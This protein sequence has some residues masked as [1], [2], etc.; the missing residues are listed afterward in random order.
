M[1]DAV[2]LKKEKTQAF[3]KTLSEERFE[4]YTVLS[5]GDEAVALRLYEANAQLS[6]ALYIPLQALEVTL[7]NRIHTELSAKYDCFWFDIPD[8]LKAK[9]QIEGVG[10]TKGRLVHDK[11]KIEAGRIIAGLSFGFW[12]GLF[13]NQYEELWRSDL[14]KIVI[15]EERPSRRKQFAGPL[16][17]IREIR[18]RVAHHECII[19]WRLN[20]HYGHMKTI[21]KR[22]SPEAHYWM[23]NNSTFEDVYKEWKQLLK[24]VHEMKNKR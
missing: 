24:D 17:Q 15:E 13:G 9:A 10:E 6:Q 2:A 18:N 23:L 3:L 11:K 21:L 20:D 7:R 19:N 4:R 16:R 12:T 14:H 8:L 22:L 1:N 5:N